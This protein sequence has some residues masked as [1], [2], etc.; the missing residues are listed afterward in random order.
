MDSITPWRTYQA[1]SNL[2]Q[3]GFPSYLDIVFEPLAGYSSITLGTAVLEN[4]VHV[5]LCCSKMK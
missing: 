2:R 5:L 1:T 4:L 3:T